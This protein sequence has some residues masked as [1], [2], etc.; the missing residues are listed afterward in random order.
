M[1]RLDNPLPVFNFIAESQIVT[2]IVFMIDQDEDS[3]AIEVALQA[4]DDILTMDSKLSQSTRPLYKQEMK[5]HIESVLI[6][7]GLALRV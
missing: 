2:G 5:K 1:C 7:D 3:R 6:D 4:L